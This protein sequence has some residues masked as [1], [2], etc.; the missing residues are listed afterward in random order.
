MISKCRITVIKRTLHQDLVDEYVSDARQEFGQ[1]GAYEDGQE[2]VIF[3]RLTVSGKTDRSA[4][5]TVFKLRFKFKNLMPKTNKRLSIIPAPFLI[6]MR[7]FR[8]KYWTINEENN[9]F[10]GIYQFESKKIAENYP[11]TFV[12]NLLA[13]RSETGTVS[14]EIIPNADLS[15]YIEKMSSG[16]KKRFSTR[17]SGPAH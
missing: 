17:Q 5:F 13:K 10:Q 15:Q 2:F 8:E 9:Y 1:C 4:G 12:F 16:S 6:G 11:N 7:G 3:R 14:Y